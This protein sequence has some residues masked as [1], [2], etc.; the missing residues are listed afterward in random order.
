MASFLIVESR[1]KLWRQP[2]FRRFWTASTVS[3]FGTPITT[4]AIQI[5]VVVNLEA[6][7]TELGVVN[8]ARWVPYLAFGLFAGV[9]AD[10]VRHRLRVL[11]MCQ[12][13]LAVLLT[14]LPVLYVA[15]LLTLSSVVAVLLAGGAVS[16]LGDASAQSVLPRL[17]DRRVL[18]AALVALIKSV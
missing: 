5:L 13:G 7:A 10:R 11:G 9:L 8:A 14:I 17:V 16:V 15:G 6:S 2:R 1:P 3:D 4:L 12:L 18:A